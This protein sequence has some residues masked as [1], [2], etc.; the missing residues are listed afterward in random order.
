MSSVNLQNWLIKWFTWI[1]ALSGMI[2]LFVT[3]YM[4]KPGISITVKIGLPILFAFYILWDKYYKSWLQGVERKLIAITTAG[5]MGKVGA[6]GPIAANVLDV[7][8]L[9]VPI[10]NIAI[11]FIIGG[12]F[13]YHTGILLLEVLALYMIPVVGKIIRDKNSRD[14]AL[15][16]EA[17]K[18]EE[19][20]EKVAE[21]MA[22]KIKLY[23]E[24]K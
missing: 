5:E 17:K 14:E 12:Q 11:I 15:K 1:V 18:D 20:A 19:L 24:P 10:A 16:E 23:N 3:Q 4:N 2:Y 13:L 22:D 8:G 6:T 7:M 9:V 21:K